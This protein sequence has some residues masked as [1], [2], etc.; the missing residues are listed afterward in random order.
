[1]YIVH[2]KNLILSATYGYVLDYNNIYGQQ[3]G[4]YVATRIYII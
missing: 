1:M 2:T 3:Y 4:M